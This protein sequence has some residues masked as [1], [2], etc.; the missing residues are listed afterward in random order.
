[1]PAAQSP[2]A[3]DVKLRPKSGRKPLQPKNIPVNQ[4]VDAGKA[5]RKP[6]WAETVTVGDSNKEN[7]PIVGTP[8][9]IEAF[10]PSLAEELSAM[11]KK[12]ELLRLD[13]ERTEKV[14]R[15]R[16]LVLEMQIRELER[17]GEMQKE[18]E[19]EVDRLYRLKQLKSSPMEISPIRSLREKQGEKK[20]E[21]ARSQEVR[22]DCEC[23]EES[24]DENSLQN[25]NSE[26]SEVMAQK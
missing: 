3:G 24:V 14:L 21:E 20:T 23:E 16:D 25:S 12:I 8:V 19:M 26:C 7:R 11:R 1:M 10:E 13:W 9:K 4:T 2:I 5:K 18:L 22:G 15:E 6:E 17:R